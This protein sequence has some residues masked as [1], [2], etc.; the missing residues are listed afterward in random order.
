V[1]TS[2]LQHSLKREA[3]QL[4]GRYN[5]MLKAALDSLGKRSCGMDERWD[6][7][8]QAMIRVAEEVPRNP[9]GTSLLANPYAL[10]GEYDFHLHVPDSSAATPHLFA[11]LCAL[12]PNFRI[13][14]RFLFKV[15]SGDINQNPTSRGN[16]A[17]VA[18][19][20][21]A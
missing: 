4:A 19:R 15:T 7:L 3:A 8:W 18:G 17:C 1:I 2:D 11:R 9:Y 21:A 20:V 14:K 10:S 5:L 12:G 13:T 6:E 16:F